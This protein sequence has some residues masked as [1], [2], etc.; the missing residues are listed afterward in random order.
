[1]GERGPRPQPNII[2]ALRGNPGRRPLSL[3][4]GVNPPVA[5]PDPPDW[6]N[7][8]ALAEWHRFTAALV[9]LGLIAEIDLASVATYCQTWGDLCA[10]EAAWSEQRRQLMDKT[11]GKSAAVTMHM[12]VIT[13]PSGAKRANPFY[14][15]M[16]ELRLDLDRMARNFGANA[17]ARSRVQPSTDPGGEG[18]APHDDKRPSAQ[19]KSFAD[20]R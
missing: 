14:E 1:M 20:F 4:E 19:I 18:D 9:D 17:A 11:G 15:R 6:L 3:D 13:Q 12:H 5:V 7:D 10:M 16:R 2:K 8:D